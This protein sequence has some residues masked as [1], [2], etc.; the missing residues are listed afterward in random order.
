GADYVP[1]PQTVSASAPKPSTGLV[2]SAAP[3][4]GMYRDRATF[5]AV[6]TAGGSPVSGRPLA[7]A[8]GPQRLQAVTDSNGSAS[9]TFPLLQT[10]GEY[11]VRAAFEESQD[12]LGS[13][14]ESTFSIARQNTTLTLSGGTA[15]YSH[16]TALAAT[17]ADPST[18]TPL[19]MRDTR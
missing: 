15:H 4:G 6:L 18:P 9:V 14:A 19:R 11:A 8:F 13:A 5:T 7:F 1:G 17:D 10:P 12:L 3:S 2:F 16:S